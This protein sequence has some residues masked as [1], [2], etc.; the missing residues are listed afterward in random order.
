MTLRWFWRLNPPWSI[1]AVAPMPTMVLSDETL[2]SLPLGV[3]VIL[4]ETLMTCLPEAPAYFSKLGDGRGAGAGARGGAAAAGVLGVDPGGG[5]EDVGDLDGGGQLLGEA[6]AGAARALARVGELAVEDVVGRVGAPFGPPGGVDDGAEVGV[7]EDDAGKGAPGP[8]EEGLAVADAGEGLDGGLVDDVPRRVALGV[9]AAGGDVA[10]AADGEGAGLEPGDGLLAEDEVGG[11][12]D[13]GGVEV[14][15]AL[16]G[17]DGVLVALGLDAVVAL[18]VAVGA[19]G[20]GLHALAARVDNVDVVDA[21]AV[22]LGP[23][24]AGGVVAAGHVGAEAVRDGDLVLGVVLVVV[25]VAVDGE[26][27]LVGRDQDLLVVP[28]WMKMTPPALAAS[29]AFWTDV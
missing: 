20:D 14:V 3:I 2:T 5:A 18:L 25:R 17:E 27:A 28:G 8:A 19:Q 12:L 1:S 29:T 16:A 13:V 26:G 24:R 15:G 7:L 6:G 11:A 21:E 9:A 23:E 4:P 10:L 22:V